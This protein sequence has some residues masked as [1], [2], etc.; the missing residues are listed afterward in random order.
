MY[1]D[2][3]FVTYNLFILFRKA[4]VAKVQRDLQVRVLMYWD[5][6][7]VQLKVSAALPHSLAL[8]GSWA[9]AAAP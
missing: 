9:A 6:Q 7:D 8:R 5:T 2:T 4:V 1:D 3:F